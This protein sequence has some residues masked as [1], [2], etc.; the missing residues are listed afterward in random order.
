MHRNFNTLDACMTYNITFTCLHLRKNW[1]TQR[2]LSAG[3]WYHTWKNVINR[4]GTLLI[5]AFRMRNHLIDAEL[6]NT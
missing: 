3:N 4:L 2:N 6:M 1:G 5:D